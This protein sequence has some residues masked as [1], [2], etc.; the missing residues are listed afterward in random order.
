MAE[1][2]MDFMLRS[3]DIQGRAYAEYL[4]DHF[5]RPSNIEDL[6]TEV[7]ARIDRLKDAETDEEKLEYRRLGTRLAYLGTAVREW[8]RQIHVAP[9]QAYAEFADRIIQPRDF[10]ITFHYDDS[11]ER[12]LKRAE[13]WD[14]SWGYGFQLGAERNPSNVLILKLHGSINW[15]VSVFGGAT[16]GSFFVSPGSSSL[17]ER[18]VVHQADLNYL[19][20][21]DFTGHTYRSGGAFPCLIMPGRSKRF[22]YDTSF[23]HEFAD[24]W[25][26]LWSHATEAVRRSDQIVVCGYSMLPVD[27]RA[28]ELLLREP[29][30]DAR[31]SIVSGSQSERIAAQFSAAGFGNLAGGIGGVL[32]GLGAAPA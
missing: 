8:F 2:L 29:R 10:V 25:T 20:Y 21:H 32:R 19:G 7:Q 15:L 27:E 6:I 1:G 13:K 18:P 11:L 3:G 28:C 4:M 5:G 17:G 30:R 26:A 24:F 9:A 12:E 14:V 16:G 22:F 23:G 31:V